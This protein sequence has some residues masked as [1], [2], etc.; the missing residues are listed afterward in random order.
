MKRKEITSLIILILVIGYGAWQFYHRSFTQTKSKHLLDTVVSITATSKSKS[1]GNMID[2]VFV[3]IESL[4]DKLNDFD[5]NSL[6]WQINNSE[7]TSFPMDEDIYELLSLSDKLYKLSE[8]KFDPSIKPVLSLW[9]FGT[10]SVDYIDTLKAAVPDS[11]MLKETL[12]LVGFSKLA[13]D[14]NTLHKPAGMQLTF[15]AI[16]KGYI[17]DK[18]AQKMKEL[19][20]VSG[21]IDCRSSMIFFGSKIPQMV[22]IQHPMLSHDD[23]I[24][25]FKILNSSVGTSGNY[26]Q[27]FEQ[28]GVHYHHIIDPH[29]GYPTPNIFS[30]T[31]ITPS[32]AL[33]DGLSTAFFLMPPQKAIEAAKSLKDCELVIYYQ[34]DG[35]SVSLKSMGMKQLDFKEKL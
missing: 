9:G 30:T 11:L 25:S 7:A 1:V 15:G 5:P 35:N 26:Q 2:S 20:I 32:A 3:Y 34:Q 31:V 4:Q 24:A 28:D 29:T 19:G 18:A 10:S 13:Y 14:K 12:N 22:Y 8:G 6:L 23:Y 16:A 21:N 27:F 17:L 33:A